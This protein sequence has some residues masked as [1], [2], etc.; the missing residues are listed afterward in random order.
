M[1]A[2]NLPAIASLQAELWEA[3]DEAE[4]GMRAVK[5][6][7]RTKRWLQVRGWHAGAVQ[8]LMHPA[9]PT[10]ALVQ[11]LTHLALPTAGS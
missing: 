2:G 3:R 4:A 9:L 5:A 1:A 8:C 10:A 11:R 6:S 7:G